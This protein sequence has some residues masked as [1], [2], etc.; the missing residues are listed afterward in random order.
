M[1][2][3]AHCDGTGAVRVRAHGTGKDVD[4]AC[5]MCDTPGPGARRC[6]QCAREAGGTWVRV[7]QQAELLRDLDVALNGVQGAAQR[8]T[9]GDI[10]SQVQAEARR[11]GYPVLTSAHVATLLP[12][13]R[14]LLIVALR[15]WRAMH[16]EI[17]T[18]RTGR[19]QGIEASDAH[20]M[21]K[22]TDRLLLKVGG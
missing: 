2:A 11:S 10:V 21:V 6:E 14:E 8:P 1:A 19:K 17:E 16:V 18:Y 12:A 5:P 13:E 7:D 15:T 9:L 22:A 4:V 20:E 3:C